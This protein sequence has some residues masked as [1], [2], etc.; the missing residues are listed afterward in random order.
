MANQNANSTFWLKA[1]FIFVSPDSC[2]EQVFHNFHCKQVGTDGQ[3]ASVSR[4]SEHFYYI[5]NTEV[6]DDS[7]SSCSSRIGGLCRA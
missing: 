3:S 5:D 1:D 2:A 7:G 6:E 4:A